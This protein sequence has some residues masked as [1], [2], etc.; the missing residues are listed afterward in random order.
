MARSIDNN[1]VLPRLRGLRALVTGASSG[2]GR[3][4]ALRLA[5][6][7]ASVVVNYL[8]GDQE[9]EEVVNE[10]INIGAKGIAFQAD[11]SQEKEVAAMFKRM[12][13]EFG[14]VDILV[15]NAG[16]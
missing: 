5:R 12:V 10:I 13:D 8:T 2:I 4:T 1:S 16:I 15:N 3:A 14:G 9:A 6:E 11:V 7:G